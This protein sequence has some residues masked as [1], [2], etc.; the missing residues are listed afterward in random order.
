MLDDDEFYSLA[1][2]GV[3]IVVDLDVRQVR[4]M[5]KAFAFKLDDVELA[6]IDNGGMATAYKRF[7]QDVLERLTAHAK[8]TVSHMKPKAE[9]GDRTPKE[10]QW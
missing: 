5:G 4:V 6:L 9:G 7:G 10:L 3:D 8:K 1:T 2:E